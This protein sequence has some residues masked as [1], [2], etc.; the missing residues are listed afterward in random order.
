MAVPSKA[1]RARKKLGAGSGTSFDNA[2][3]FAATFV[4]FV[5]SSQALLSF[6]KSSDLDATAPFDMQVQSATIRAH[7]L[8]F[9]KCNQSIR[10][11]QAR[12]A[13]ENGRASDGWHACGTNVNH[14]ETRV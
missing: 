9:N 14:D 13:I 12:A 10:T 4:V 5:M 6:S 2:K 8:R 7:A 3:T 11:V 1:L